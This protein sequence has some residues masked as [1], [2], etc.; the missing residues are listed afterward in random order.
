MHN[1][2]NNSNNNKIPTKLKRKLKNRNRF[3]VTQ[4]TFKKHSYNHN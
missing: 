2:T 3:L 4:T 1:E